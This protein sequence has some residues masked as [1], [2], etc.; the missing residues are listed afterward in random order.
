VKLPELKEFSAK[1]RTKKDPAHDFTHIERMI[2]MC[3]A[4]AP[5]E[6]DIN[7]VIESA[8]FHGLLREEASIRNFLSS[9]AF[10]DS[11]IESMMRTVRNSS[12]NAEPKAVEAKVLHDANVLD[13]LGAIG[14]ARAFTKGGY[15]RQTINQTMEIIKKNT[16]RDLY[17]PMGRK[18]GEQR[19][20]FVSKFLKRLEDEL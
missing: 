9:L 16:L 13:A 2:E 6:T 15:E 11:R 1:L 5:P 4:I 18:I 20:R 7:L 12:S 14:I 8:H 17:T 10:E 3:R 19:K